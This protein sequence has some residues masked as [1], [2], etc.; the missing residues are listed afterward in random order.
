MKIFICRS[1]IL[2]SCVATPALLFRKRFLRSEVSRGT[3]LHPT[4]RVTKG[5]KPLLWG[6]MKV[7]NVLDNEFLKAIRLAR[8]N[9]WCT[10]PVC[11]TCGAHDFCAVLKKRGL[12]N[13]ADDLATVDLNALRRN[14]EWRDPLRLALDQLA[15]PEL[16][17][18]VF[19][20]WYPQ[21]DS[22]IAVADLVL[23]YFVRR[24]ALFA[25]MSVEVLTKRRDKCVELACKTHD[26]SLLESL[27]YTLGHSYRR[28]AVLNA[29]VKEKSVTSKRV[30]VAAR[31]NDFPP[32]AP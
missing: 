18:R 6:E 28:N 25:P 1:L 10:N 26:E 20:A 30:L 21:L 29:V 5:S 12:G 7:A 2:A 32:E 24:G 31:R 27:I 4:T 17:D 14:G 13:L 23:F 8:E 22:Q 3:P 9:R 16:E 15:S 11:T 19:L